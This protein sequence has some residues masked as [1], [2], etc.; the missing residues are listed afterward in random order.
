[1]GD[2][3]WEAK[4]Y[5][6]PREP[7][8]QTDLE[9]IEAREGRGKGGQDGKAGAGGA[10]GGAGPFHALTLSFSLPTAAYATMC[11]RELTR[12]TTSVA[13]HA[14]RTQLAQQRQREAAAA[15]K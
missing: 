12:Q 15:E 5:S 4:R 6:D 1:M 9:M 10:G 3:Q 11:L 2:L 7:L 8:V 14:A 13:A